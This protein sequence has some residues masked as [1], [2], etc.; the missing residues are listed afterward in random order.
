M[1]VRPG[2][3]RSSHL[4]REIAAL[5]ARLM[6]EEGIGDYGFA[7]RKAARQLGVRDAEPLPANAEVEVELR[8]W[9]ALYQDDEQ[10]ERIA[11]MRGAAL[12]LMQRV[13]SFRP[14]LVGAVADGTAGRYAQ[15]DL[16]LHPDSAKDVEIFFLGENIDYQH[17]SSRHP[18]P[19]PPDAVLELEWNEFPVRL[20]I[21]EHGRPHFGRR[22]GERL[23]ARQLAAL[24]NPTDE[25]LG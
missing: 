19:N 13:A 2:T 20:A 9:L 3:S 23:H 8:A 15:I 25:D 12:D 22:S 1:R 18:G 16:E 17:R 5:A 21:H 24:L 6:A 11:L 4:R 14:Y 10:P 7:K